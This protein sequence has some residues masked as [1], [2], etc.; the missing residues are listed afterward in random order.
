MYFLHVKHKLHFNLRDLVQ[1]RKESDGL[2]GLALTQSYDANS[3]RGSGQTQS[4]PT[5]PQD[6]AGL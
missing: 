2:T 4:K 3:H 6:L 5:V 1:R